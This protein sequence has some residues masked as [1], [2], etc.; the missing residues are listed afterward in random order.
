V[1]DLETYAGVV[2]RTVA[3]IGTRA[4]T[5]LTIH[6]K[7][8]S[9]TNVKLTIGG[10]G[11]WLRTP[12][13]VF[14]GSAEVTIAASISTNSTASPALLTVANNTTV[15][16]GTLILAGN[17]VKTDTTGGTIAFSGTS[18]LAVTRVTAKILNVANITKT[19][20]HELAFNPTSIDAGALTGTLTLDEGRIVLSADNKLGTME[21]KTTAT[22][23]GSSR[24][25]MLEAGTTAL[26]FSNAL[27]LEQADLAFS[28]R[29]ASGY[30]E[31]RRA[32]FN[33]STATTTS[34][35]NT[36][37]VTRRITVDLL[38]EIVI[39]ANQTFTSAAGVTLEKTGMGRLVLGGAPGTGGGTHT[40]ANFS[41]TAGETQVIVAGTQTT[42]TASTGTA[43]G[44]GERIAASGA[45]T[46]VSVRAGTGGASDTLV[47][48]AGT[49]IALS[50]GAQ[51]KTEA[52]PAGTSA[53]PADARAAPRVKL[54]SGANVDF[55]DNGTTWGEIEFGGAV[56]LGG[57]TFTGLATGGATRFAGDLTFNPTYDDYAASIGQNAG[58]NTE[59]S[60]T[61][62][63][64]FFND[65][66][67]LGSDGGFGARGSGTVTLAGSLFK[68]SGTVDVDA[69]ITRLIVNGADG[70]NLSGGSVV[71]L[72]RTDQI[73]GKVIFSGTGGTMLLN[74]YSQHTAGGGTDLSVTIGDGARG[75][76]V[77][78]GAGTT[79]GVDAHDGGAGTAVALALGNLSF[80]STGGYLG[81]RGYLGDFQYSGGTAAVSGDGVA[82]HKDAV[83]VSNAASL[84]SSQLANQVWFYGY[85]KGAVVTGTGNALLPANG[86]I[87]STW[88]G[89]SASSQR[90]TDP[91]VW[92]DIYVSTT[93]AT[94][95]QTL[96]DVPNAPGAIARGGIITAE[97]TI[98]L[99]GD[100]ITVGQ[101]LQT[102]KVSGIGYATSTIVFDSGVAGVPAIWVGHSYNNGS[103]DVHGNIEYARIILRSDLIVVP[104]SYYQ[105]WG[106]TPI[107]EEGGVRSVTVKSQTPTAVG[108]LPAN[109]AWSA[110][111]LLRGTSS[112]SSYSGGTYFEHGTGADFGGDLG[113][114]GNQLGTW[115]GT[116]KIVVNSD[117]WVDG[118]TDGTTATAPVYTGGS[119]TGSSA[120]TG[121][122]YAPGTRAVASIYGTD[123]N[124][125]GY[126]YMRRIKN[127]LVLYGHLATGSMYFDYSGNVVVSNGP[128]TN[129]LGP[130][131][132]TG[133]LRGGSTSSA[134]GAS[135]PSDSTATL[136]SQILNRRLEGKT[137][138]ID[139]G[140]TPGP[141]ETGGTLSSDYNV[142]NAVSGLNG[143]AVSVV[144]G[145]NFAF[146]GTGTLSFAGMNARTMLSPNSTF[147]GG[148]VVYDGKL[149][150]GAAAGVAPITGNITLGALVSGENYAGSGNI[151]LYSNSDNVHAGSM[152][153]ETTGGRIEV[154]G[155]K[156]E[157]GSSYYYT[158]VNVLGETS[159][160]RLVAPT[161]GIVLSGGD[162]SITG[163]SLNAPGNSGYRGGTLSLGSSTLLSGTTFY[164]SLGTNYASPAFTTSSRIGIVLDTTGA[165]TTGGVAVQDATLSFSN[166]AGKYTNS[167]NPTAAGVLTIQR[168]TKSG[169]GTYTLDGSLTRVNVALTKHSF[170]HLRERLRQRQHH[171]QRRHT[172]TRR[173]QP[174]ERQHARPC[175][176]RA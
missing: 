22:A 80:D 176:R 88:I 60:G 141:Y 28:R 151:T 156:I 114:S 86:F 24:E 111:W 127:E 82:T 162:I 125:A 56:A 134:A 166:T 33:P 153:V 70:L 17:E 32:T 40:F 71:S 44:K 170:R 94:G 27:D 1:F 74:G 12:S 43:L 19:G 48:G 105:R 168:L 78:G 106:V 160:L 87:E 15:A 51:L 140:I 96:Y 75:E 13:I 137:G 55:G 8:A 135:G 73:G 115:L 62:Q 122:S 64:L 150:I 95:G 100:V 69:S 49:T 25:I 90:W 99:Q 89:T 112:T 136:A 45:Q 157:I 79:A 158:Q 2:G 175:R 84:T 92:A 59:L 144:F 118:S 103:A 145:E 143:N 72:S 6:G 163:T 110:Q 164:G 39:G 126:T 16:G 132:F 77:L 98:L 165:V 93:T 52:T 50:N 47:I 155:G 104:T 173:E 34:L 63:T 119:G 102:P 68:K 65:E 138:G 147:S 121:G 159:T 42:G 154:A 20:G 4:V 26:T 113:I 85:E 139:G 83:T 161:G 142:G 30:S 108:V 120:Y 41:A 107:S 7:T 5:G 133:S 67:A 97:Q 61:A 57:V 169:A 128:E 3:N 46:V 11:D 66:S 36:T 81:I 91:L 38:T 130:I 21:I 10:S 101:M 116:G 117:H 35:S 174:V 123:R 148:L 54:E 146:T 129:G 149:Y 124:S 14:T 76:F 23:S 171:H 152:H 172:Q 37:G 31:Y 167:T 29:N 18:A 109:P 9:A 58:F 131:I 53:S